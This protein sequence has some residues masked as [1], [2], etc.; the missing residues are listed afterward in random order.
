MT[1]AA[2]KLECCGKAALMSAVTRDRSPPVSTTKVPNIRPTGHNPARQA[3]LSGPRS[4]PNFGGRQR[5]F[6]DPKYLANPREFHKDFFHCYIPLPELCKFHLPLIQILLPVWGHNPHHP[7]P[8]PKKI[9]VLCFI[10]CEIAN[11]VR[12]YTWPSGKKGWTPLVY[13]IDHHCD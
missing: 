8:P 6:F 13:N 5:F 3:F 12:L 10:G 2:W 4:L 11:S 1:A 9:V 7:P